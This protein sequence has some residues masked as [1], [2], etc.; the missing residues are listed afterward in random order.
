VDEH[1]WNDAAAERRVIAGLSGRGAKAVIFV[2]Y[3]TPDEPFSLLRHYATFRNIG[4]AEDPF[5][6]VARP[7]VL[8]MS[9]DAAHRLF[10]RLGLSL[11]EVMRHARTGAFVS[12]RIADEATLAIRT[13][14]EDASGSNVVA[15]LEGS[16]PKLKREAVVFSAHYDAYGVKDG[17]VHAGAADN[18][19]GTAMMLSVAE[20]LARSATRPKRTII[21]LATTGEEYGLLGAFHWVDHPTWPIRR[22]AANINF[23]GIGTETYAP[24]DRIVGF[25]AEFSELGDVL[26]EVVR[27]ADLTF[28]IDPFPEQRPFSRS[29]QAAF[30]QKGVPAMALLGLPAGDVTPAVARARRWLATDYHQPSDTVRVDWDWSGPSTLASVAML[31]GWRVANAPSPPRWHV[32]APYHRWRGDGE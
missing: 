3:E 7:P 11:D 25:G 2:D 12:R 1:A 16:D 8:F 20:G 23:D 19:L 29:D 10:E 26:A 13:R 32:G 27:G 9:D 14:R 5:A 15:M 30:A 17:Q 28:T 24:V 31:V 6:P 4:L 18:A 22:V 21:F